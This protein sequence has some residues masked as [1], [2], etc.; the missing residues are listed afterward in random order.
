MALMVRALMAP[1]NGNIRSA[2]LHWLQL[3]NHLGDSL[4]DGPDL[5]PSLFHFPAP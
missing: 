4:C 1:N 2:M 3:F 5:P